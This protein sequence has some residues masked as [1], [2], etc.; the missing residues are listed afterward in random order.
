[1]LERIT[2]FMSH[3][4]I[5]LQL[6]NATS[7]EERF[8]L[9]VKYYL[10]GWHIRPKGVKKPYN[11]CLGEYFRCKWEVDGEKGVYVAEQVSHHPPVSAYYYTL[12]NKVQVSGELRPKSKFLGNSAASMM[13]GHSKITVAGYPGEEYYVTNP[14]VYARGLLFGT[15]LMELGDTATVKCDKTGYSAEFEFITK[16]FFSGTYNAIKGKIKK[17]NDVLYNLTGKWTDV[18]YIQKNTRNAPQEVF[19]DVA[20]SS[21]YPKTVKN[22]QEQGEYE[23]RRLWQ[24]VTQGLL[25]KNLDKATEEKNSIEDRQRKMRSDN[26]TEYDGKFFKASGVGKEGKEGWFCELEKEFFQKN[27]EWMKRVEGFIFKQ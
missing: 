4:D 18:M 25:S 1:M 12:G 7:E 16:G 15:M 3:P 26:P 9:A 5:L 22:E 21:I 17:G 14:N 2:D 27:P 13:H 19:F 23:S 24:K 10:S 6:A 11:P 8:L 20:A